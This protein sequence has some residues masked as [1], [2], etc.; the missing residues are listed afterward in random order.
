MKEIKILNAWG[1]QGNPCY[2]PSAT[3]NGGGHDQP[4]GGMTVQGGKAN[5]YTNHEDNSCGD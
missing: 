2:D 4:Y 5:L 1:S 3:N